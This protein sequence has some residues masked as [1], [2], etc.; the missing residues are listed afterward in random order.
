MSL[1]LLSAIK[2]LRTEEHCCKTQS[3]VYPHCHTP[4]VT[5]TLMKILCKQTHTH[6]Y[7]NIPVFRPQ[8]GQQKF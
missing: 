8:E 4:S 7:F 6:L 3:T 2:I 1:L 5:P